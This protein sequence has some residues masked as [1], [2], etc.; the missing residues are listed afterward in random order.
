MGKQR[1][2][3]SKYETKLSPKDEAEFQQWFEQQHK[4]GYIGDGDYKYYKEHGYG[5]DYDFR[6][7]FDSDQSKEPVKAKDGKW[8]WDDYGK[9]PNEPTFS[10]QSLYHG[11]DGHFGGKWKGNEF[12]PYDK[13][14]RIKISDNRKTDVIT[15]DP[16]TDTNNLSINAD[17]DVVKSIIESAKKK[18]VDPNIALSI[19]FQ[20]T[21]LGSKGNEKNPLQDNRHNNDLDSSMDFLRSKIDDAKKRLGKK[22]D[23]EVLQSWNGYGKMMVDPELQAAGQKQSYY[24]LDLTKQ[25]IVGVGRGIDMNKTPL[26]GKRYVDVRDNV[27]KTNPDIQNMIKEVYGG[28]P[29]HATN[30]HIKEAMQK[31]GHTDT[32]DFVKWFNAEKGKTIIPIE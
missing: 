21:G 4:K 18:G 16:I 19:A 10:N 27:I 3:P 23:E 26:A 6:A 8:H 14:D 28:D 31:T 11:R 12:T 1:I 30:E 22:T 15:G 20:E 32:D 2:D 5:Y 24:G 29:I 25:P 9:K 7:L 13:I 17:K